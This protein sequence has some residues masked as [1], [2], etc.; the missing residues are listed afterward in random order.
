MLVPFV[1]DSKLQ[2]QGKLIKKAIRIR[3]WGLLIENE[4]L[5]DN[6]CRVCFRDR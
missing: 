2:N 1:F 4:G 5:G 3:K 6:I